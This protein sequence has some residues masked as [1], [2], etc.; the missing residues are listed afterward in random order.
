MHTRYKCWK[1]ILM[2]K[3][4][5]WSVISGFITMYLYTTYSLVRY[6]QRLKLP[7]NKFVCCSTQIY[8]CNTV[9][10]CLTQVACI[11]V[12]EATLSVALARRTQVKLGF[13]SYM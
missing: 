12:A 5:G 10:K 6:V 9:S 7:F 3:T 11:P 13:C 8:W 4:L 1:M 2:Y